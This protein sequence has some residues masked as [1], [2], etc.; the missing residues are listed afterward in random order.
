MR[1]K[2]KIECGAGG[3]EGRYINIGMKKKW[4]IGQPENE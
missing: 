2:P 3:V 1:G 4:I